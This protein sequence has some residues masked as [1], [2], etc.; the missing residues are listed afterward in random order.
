M[1]ESLIFSKYDSF[2]KQIFFFQIAANEV[3]NNYCA[4]SSNTVLY[5]KQWS[6]F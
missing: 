4:V 3:E 2:L 1:E 6:H 5:H